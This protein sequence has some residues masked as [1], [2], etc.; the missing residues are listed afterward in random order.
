[1]ATKKE[2]N[3]WQ[4]RL[5]QGFLGQRGV[6]GERLRVLVESERR[7]A[8]A[9]VRGSYGLTAIAD[10]FQDFYMQTFEEGA[11][12]GRPKTVN[13]HYCAAIV[14]AFHRLRYA[15]NAYYQGYP[16]E[17]AAAVRT[18]IE[19]GLYLG[20]ILNGYIAYDDL[21]S[22]VKSKDD[23][24]LPINKLLKNK[25]EHHDQLNKRIILMMR[26]EKSGLES[27]DQSLLTE[28]WRSLHSHVHN[29]ESSII[30]NISDMEESRTVSLHPEYSG[31]RSHHFATPLVFACW[32]LHRA[33]PFVSNPSDYSD[34]WG[35]KA[36]LLNE[37][38]ESYIR[39]TESP[40]AP[41]I[42]RMVQLKYQFDQEL[43][44][45]RVEVK[46]SPPTA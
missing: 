10:C 9:A 21:F 7:Y 36:S 15:M 6:F 17:G 29:A 31:R 32:L 18:L 34:S 22:F 42:I 1:M 45:S 13:V 23:A 46:A 25:K 43:A 40:A 14:A 12:Q 5:E 16:Y 19:V 24:A 2:S 27:A 39:G 37:S 35:R 28:F 44:W 11:H 30:W 3:H 41:A 38:F 4:E 20:A 26:G 8:E 33:L